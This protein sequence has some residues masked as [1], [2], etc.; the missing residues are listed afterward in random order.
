MNGDERCFRIEDTA[1]RKTDDVVEEAHRARS[2]AVLVVDLRVDVCAIRRSNDCGCVLVV[3]LRPSANQDLIDRCGTGRSCPW[4]GKVQAEEKAA[5][6][7][8]STRQKGLGKFAGLVR[9]QLRLHAMHARRLLQR[10]YH[11]VDKSAFDGSAI[12][13]P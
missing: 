13:T 11:V 12:S 3:V 9:Q 10:L 4:A 8:K 2:C 1:S 7:L 6:S 5:I